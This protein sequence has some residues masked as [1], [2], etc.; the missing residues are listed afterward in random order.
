MSNIVNY[1]TGRTVDRTDYVDDGFIDVYERN[2]IESG[3][4]PCIYY[5]LNVTAG[6]GLTVNVAPGA[7]RG[8]D[9]SF[10]INGG[11]STPLP[12]V[13]NN[14]TTITTINIPAN[15]TGW[16]VLNVNIW[17]SVI[18][19]LGPSSNADLYE[20]GASTSS[21]VP[22]GS[23]AAPMFVT[24]LQP[25]TNS[26]WPFTQIPLAQ[27]VSNSTSITSINQNYNPASVQRAFDFQASLISIAQGK[28]GTFAY[29]NAD[30]VNVPVMFNSGAYIPPNPTDTN[31]NRIANQ[32]YADG[33]FSIT[34]VET[35]Y[36]K[37][38][39]GLIIQWFQFD[40]SGSITLPTP[41]IHG[42]LS[43]SI[44]A[45]GDYGIY[46][47]GIQP[48]PSNPLTRVVIDNH[49]NYGNRAIVVGW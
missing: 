32:T 12:T 33:V 39:G 26:S 7:A 37:L 36:A 34:D 13:V 3:L 25:N 28:L 1:K 47:P 43:A 22:S 30:N 11:T 23:S 6:S 14:V 29:Q 18:N 45:A 8:Q 42:F 17:D 41:W 38:P 19:T 31:G 48:D 46:I 9:I 10:T 5:G 2:L 24:T 27:V 21:A 15:S 40:A 20:I 35:G 49:G 4:L 16:I 44:S